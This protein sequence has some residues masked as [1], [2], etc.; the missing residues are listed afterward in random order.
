MGNWKEGYWYLFLHVEY[1][2][3]VTTLPMSLIIWA[4]WGEGA[5]MKEGLEGSFSVL[6]HCGMQSNL[7]PSKSNLRNLDLLSNTIVINKLSPG[8]NGAT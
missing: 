5:V 1:R 6:R 2:A 8:L 3:A 4:Y 7:D